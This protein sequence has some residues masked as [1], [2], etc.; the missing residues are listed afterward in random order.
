M[1]MKS[2]QLTQ[3]ANRQFWYVEHPN[4]GKSHFL[5]GTAGQSVEHSRRTVQ[6]RH[7]TFK[8][9]G[10][11]DAIID[12]SGSLYE[13]SQWL[14]AQRGSTFGR[15][16]V[17]RI[18]KAK[19]LGRDLELRVW[20]ELFD[21][22]IARDDV[23]LRQACLQ[24]LIAGHVVRVLQMPGLQ[25]LANRLIQTPR[26][27]EPP[28]PEARLERFTRRLAQAKVLVPAC[29]SRARTAGTKSGKSGASAAALY[30]VNRLGIGVFR[31]VEQ[32]VCCYVPGEVSHIENVMAR[33]YKERHTRSLSSSET[34]T[35]DTSTVESER[36]SDT[37]TAQRNEM[38]TEVA[39]VLTS[40]NTTGFNA[41]TEVSGAL[42][43]LEVR[44][45]AAF[46]Y[47]LSNGSTNS[48]ADA[49]VYAEEVTRSALDRV[50]QNQTAKRTSRMVQE[51]EENNKHGFD[52]R[53]GDTHVTGVY[54]WVDILYRNRLINY[55]KH[56]MVE[57]LVPEPAAFYLKAM[58]PKKGG[59]DQKPAAG[60][61]RP[62]PPATLSEAGIANAAAIT[63]GNYLGFAGTFD[64]QLEPPETED[65]APVSLDLR[66]S[67]AMGGKAPKGKKNE[68]F[69]FTLMIPPTYQLAKADVTVR[70]QYTRAG[71]NLGT[72]M[73]AT[74]AGQRETIGDSLKKTGGLGKKLWANL[75]FDKTYDDGSF[76]QATLQ[77]DMTNVFDFNVYGQLET[78]WSDH[79]YS[80]WQER[81]YTTL[82]TAY[83]RQYDQYE[84]D[85]AAWESQQETDA[86]PAGKKATADYG[87][88]ASANRELEKQELK[89][90]SVEML[91]RPYGR[92]LGQDF[93]EP[94]GCGVPSARQDAAW[95][96]YASQVKFFEQSF[97][98]NSMA[99]IFYPYYWADRCDWARLL[100]TESSSDP[101]FTS[102]LRSGMARVVVP[103]RRGF[104][105]AITYYL[106]TGD[107]WLGGDLV[108]HTDDELYLSVAEELREIEGVVEEEWE[109]RMP[110]TLTIVQGESV[111]LEDQGLPCCELVQT[112]ETSTGLKR[113]TA[114]LEGLPRI[115]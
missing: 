65:G 89:R 81:C 2:P 115:P 14:F 71:A 49:R 87:Q 96:A 27:P 86:G 32:E 111:Y 30:G 82:Q 70:F 37:S 100:Q 61:A 9:S 110:T 72:Y 69:K 94:G 79:E 7:E 36:Q 17:Q 46:D 28:P 25:A 31:K 42:G 95:E 114:L 15:R 57:F 5:K 76:T 55:G 78:K 20:D 67:D 12:L 98:W 74:L 112:D 40:Q 83:E 53:K 88:S 45:G 56:L 104:E 77:L 22:L 75:A 80:A 18:D 85:L 50:V 58:R 97:E 8:S 106:D 23:P 52:N 34:T 6:S 4:P 1:S 24:M 41:N 90:N 59:K 99:Y 10:G 19:P 102:F 3:R 84:L 48:N 62:V 66:P 11:K 103:V 108:L 38:A 68:S 39:S 105:D 60:G 64:T 101:L 109:T 35:E 91:M 47:G 29:F 21:Q 16:D 107:I 73:R 54:R 93:L 26:L 33:E 44:A 51:Y 63:R 113:S 43:S 92:T 13:V